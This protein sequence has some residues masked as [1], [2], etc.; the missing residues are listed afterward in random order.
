[1]FLLPFFGLT[2]IGHQLSR[3]FVVLL[4]LAAGGLTLLALADDYFVPLARQLNWTPDDEGNQRHPEW[5]F[6]D[7][8]AFQKRLDASQDFLKARE[9]AEHDAHRIHELINRREMLPDGTL[10]DVRLIPRQGAVSL[11]RN[12]PL[13]RGPRLFAQHCASCHDYV[14]PAGQSPW[15]FAPERNPDEAD[16]GP[17]LFGFA[18]RTWIK[19]LLNPEQ[20]VG[21]AYFGNTNHTEGRMATWVAQHAELLADDAAKGDDDVDAIA[22]ALSAQARLPAQQEADAHDSELIR[23]GLGLIEQNCTKGCHKLGD[24]GQLGLAPDLTGYGSYEWMLGLVSDPMHERFYRMENDRM[25]SFAFNLD[26]PERNNLSVREVSLIV[27][28]LRGQYYVADSERPVLSHSAAQAEQA[29]R[30]ARATADSSAA[31][32]GAPEPSEETERVRAERL[33]ARN[34]AACHSHTDEHGS[35][36]AAKDPSAPNLFGFGSRTWLAGFLDPEQVATPKYF[37]NTRHAEGDMVTFVND[38]FAELEDDAKETLQALI[39]AVSAEAALPA[40]AEADQQAEA[41][42]M[43]E[44]GREAI[45]ESFARTRRSAA[46]ARGSSWPIATWWPTARR[47]QPVAIA[48]RS[49]DHARRQVAQRHGLQAY[50]DYQRAAGRPPDSSVDVAVPPDVSSDVIREI[51]RHNDHIR[52]MLAQKPLGV[53]YAKRRDRPAV[54]AAGHHAGRQPEHALR[55]VDAGL[56]VPADRGCLGEPVLASIDMRAIP[57]WMPW[58]QRQGWVTLRIMSIHHLDTFRYWFGDPV[59]VF[60]SV[61]EDPR[62]ARKFEHEDGI[63]LYILEYE[64]GLARRVV[65]RRLDGTGAWRAPR[66]TSRSAGAS[67]G[68]EGMARGTIGWPDYP[69]PTPSTLDFTTCGNPA[70]GSQPRWKRSLVSRTPSW[71]RW[72]NCCAPWKTAPSRRS[73]AGTI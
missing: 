36:I 51:V 11:L 64:N 42:G 33:F 38:S 45:A 71:A 56:Q 32:V 44:K 35:G 60:A 49:P 54:R 31:V 28:W 7:E 52:G 58:Q 43:L 2:R 39:A 15:Q 34:C 3:A 13:S 19:G 65:G 20:I 17:N 50:D 46:S 5:L 16:G 9:E 6:A 22:A 69:H 48:S 37:G 40:Q 29:V 53:N 61:R 55:P 12:D 21:P 67:K 57:H 23:R 18:T 25:P 68:M 8:K 41:D 26:E 70:T 63:C 10:S 1:L 59:R 66:R 73:A 4:L 72:P 62:T 47:L 30:L 24:H 27:D 14:D